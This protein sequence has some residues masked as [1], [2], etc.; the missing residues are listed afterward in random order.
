MKGIRCFSE[1]LKIL[2]NMSSILKYLFNLIFTFAD[3]SEIEKYEITGGNLHA[4]VKIGFGGCLKAFQTL[5]VLYFAPLSQSKWQERRMFQ[6]SK[7]NRVFKTNVNL[8][9]SPPYIALTPNDS[10]A[11]CFQGRI[12]F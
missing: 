9:T 12:A 10:F 1:S 6:L 5:S 2:V 4:N 8:I 11:I 7:P 3:F